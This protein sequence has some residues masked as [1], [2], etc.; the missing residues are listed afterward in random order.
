MNGS[1][2]T[3]VMQTCTASGVLLKPD[4]PASPTDRFW[5][6]TLLNA[7][8]AACRGDLSVTH[9]SLT[10]SIASNDSI[11]VGGTAT[12]LTWLYALGVQLCV[13]YSLTYGEWLSGAE[14]Y[15]S[16][17]SRSMQYEDEKKNDQDLKKLAPEL[18]VAASVAFRPDDP[19]GTLVELPATG[20]E[21]GTSSSITIAAGP[22]YGT[23]DFWRTAPVLANGWALLG[24][25]D[26]FIGVSRQRI[27]NLTM[28]RAAA[29]GSIKIRLVGKA[30]EVVHLSAASRENA[31]S[32]GPR[33]TASTAS[34]L[35]VA[36]TVGVWKLCT[37]NVVIGSDGSAESL[38][39][40][41]ESSSDCQ[42]WSDQ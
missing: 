19:V 10:L 40:P 7:D 39:P 9:T 15:L 34:G 27:T 41:T 37:M 42:T 8:A 35:R 36:P 23:A 24:E 12:T 6:A 21:T 18:E 14:P 29:G 1:N 5:L 16:S 17:P 13:P 3:L 32:G 38:L 33:P 25:L 28:V 22:D 4:R 26:K 11:A 31:T 2:R 30:G 20:I